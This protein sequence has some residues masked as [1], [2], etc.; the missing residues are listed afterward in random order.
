[1][2]GSGLDQVTSME[3]RSFLAY[4]DPQGRGRLGETRSNDIVD[5]P[6][7][8]IPQGIVAAVCVVRSASPF[9]CAAPLLLSLS[10]IYKQIAINPVFKG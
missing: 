3:A 1:M 10:V 5:K 2:W 4:I 7:T 9:P 8:N 6:Q